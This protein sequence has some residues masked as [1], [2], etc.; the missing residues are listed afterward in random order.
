MLHL[1]ALS[2]AVPR[3]I[4]L[5]FQASLCI[6]GSEELL[7]QACAARAGDVVL[8]PIGRLDASALRALRR[9]LPPDTLLV[10]VA[11]TLAEATAASVEFSLYDYVVTRP[12]LEPE[13]GF[14]LGVR[15]PTRS[16][17]AN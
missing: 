6:V 4:D 8:V 7:A 2:P 1:V 13:L 14:L 17:S 12:R 15:S 11:P 5:P 10:A 16:S 3:V 9:R